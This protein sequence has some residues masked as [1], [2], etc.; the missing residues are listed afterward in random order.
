VPEVR[1]AQLQ[2]LEALLTEHTLDGVWLDFIRWPCHWESPTP[3]LPRTSFDRGTVARFCHDTGIAIPDG[4]PSLAAKELLGPYESEWT[5]W[6][7]QQITNWVIEAR[8][9]VD[10]LRPGVLLGLF[11]V[12]WRLADHSGAILKVIG[13]DYR[14]LGA[15]V[16]VFSPMVYHRMCGQPTHWITDIVRE[17]HALTGR[18]VWPIV[19]SVDEPTPVS[20]DEYGE[21]LDTA[22]QGAVSEGVLVFNLKSTLAP[23]KLAATRARFAHD[24]AP[25]T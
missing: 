11:G 1:Q 5:V 10:R 25:G 19:Q 18:P 20:A 16:D 7:C 23:G 22:L 14:A 15:Y 8:A 13:Q 3:Y 17:V 2:A 4:N 6:R 12:P 21:A 9:I 24:C